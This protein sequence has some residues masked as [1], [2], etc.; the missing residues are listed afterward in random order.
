LAK[1]KEKNGKAIKLFL[2]YD[3]HWAKWIRRK[4]RKENKRRER[5]GKN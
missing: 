1:E 4:I 5:N 3:R 2:I